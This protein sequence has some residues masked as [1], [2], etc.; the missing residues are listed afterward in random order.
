MKLGKLIYKSSYPPVYRC[1]LFV[2]IFIT[3]VTLLVAL[4]GLLNNMSYEDFL[5]MI[6]LPYLILVFLLVFLSVFRR[7]ELSYDVY[8]NGLKIFDYFIPWDDVKSIKQLKKI[9]PKKHITFYE[10][11]LFYLSKLNRYITEKVVMFGEKTYYYEIVTKQ[12]RRFIFITVNKK[13]FEKAVGKAMFKKLF[14]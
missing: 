12:S 4:H 11:L 5:M 6:F 14:R 7:D 13:K 1:L 3:M 2:F 9:V 10:R 8:Y